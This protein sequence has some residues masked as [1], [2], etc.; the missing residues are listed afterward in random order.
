[1]KA[2]R[3]GVLS[4]VVASV[5]CL[6]PPLLILLGLGT[7]GLGSFFGKYH[8]YFILAGMFL[9]SIAWGSYF[10]EKRRCTTEGCKMIKEG[11]TKSILLLATVIVAVFVGLNVYTYARG[12]GDTTLSTQ[13]EEKQITIPVT[14]MSCF[15]CELSVQNALGRLKGVKSS[16]ASAKE[17]NVAVLYDPNQVMV[18][19]LVATIN[20]TGY[21]ASFPKEQNG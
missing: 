3:L 13:A 10:K 16:K 19:D 17:G 6:G 8:W 2:H 7:L 11:T 14:G 5:C 9:L 4:G 15:T 18:K 12:Q 21:N 1:M 20:K